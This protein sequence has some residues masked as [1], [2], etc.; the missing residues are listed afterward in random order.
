MLTAHP[1]G[2]RQALNNLLQSKGM[3]NDIQWDV[4][5]QGLPHDPVWYAICLGSSSF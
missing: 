3:T 2:P 1:S 4:A 5:R